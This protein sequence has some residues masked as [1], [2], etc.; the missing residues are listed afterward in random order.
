MP[1]PL[2]RETI[3]TKQRKIAA[4]AR[5]TPKRV[6][7]TLAHHI[8]VGWLQEAYRRTRKRSAAGV[9]GVTAAQY[10]TAFGGEPHQRAGAVPIRPVSSRPG[11]L[12]R[13]PATIGCPRGDGQRLLT[14]SRAVAVPG[15]R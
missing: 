7:T 15:L 1:R 5:H 6:L 14:A 2:S 4:L 9:D 3:S 10:E 13:P 12:R 8:D 11:Y